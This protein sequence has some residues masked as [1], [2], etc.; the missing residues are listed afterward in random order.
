MKEKI[1][2]I[3]KDTIKVTTEQIIDLTVIRNKIKSLEDEADKITLIDPKGYSDEIVEL[4][5]R[6]NF[7]REDTKSQFLKEASFLRDKLKSYGVKR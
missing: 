5:S 3:N 2:I 1:R 7:E 4:I 6:E